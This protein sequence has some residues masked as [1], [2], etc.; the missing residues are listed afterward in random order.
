MLV[1]VIRTLILYLVVVLSLRV[2]GKRQI[3]ELQPSEKTGAAAK[4]YRGSSGLLS[5]LI[6]LSHF[7]SLLLLAVCDI[8]ALLL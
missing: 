6:L 5:F 1:L 8:I 7:S 3:G 4:A 2:M